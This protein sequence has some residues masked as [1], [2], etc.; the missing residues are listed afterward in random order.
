[1]SGIFPI[2]LGFKIEGFRKGFGMLGGCDCGFGVFRLEPR[3][4]VVILDWLTL[5]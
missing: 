5:T 1:M 2:F 4:T 3:L